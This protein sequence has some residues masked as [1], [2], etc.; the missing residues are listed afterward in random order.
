M[1][2][3]SYNVFKWAVIG[4]I[5]GLLPFV[6]PW[7][8]S[9]LVSEFFSEIALTVLWSILLLVVYISVRIRKTHPD[10]AKGLWYGWLAELS[11]GILTLII[12]F[13][14][15]FGIIYGN[16]FGD[17]FF[18][19]V[20]SNLPQ[21]A[22]QQLVLQFKGEPVLTATY[23]ARHKYT[24]EVEGKGFSRAEIQRGFAISCFDGAASTMV[25]F[26]VCDQE[27]GSQS[28][29]SCDSTAE[30]YFSK[31]SVAYGTT[32][33]NGVEFFRFDKNLS[34]PHSSVFVKEYLVA[35]RENDTRIEIEYPIKTPSSCLSE[36]EFQDI[37]SIVDSIELV[38][39]YR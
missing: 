29:G 22:P 11:A 4:F 30:S 8:L 6:A 18:Y 10:I 2:K 23:P 26:L 17:Q 14:F 12:G 13:V 20:S 25:S 39:R 32:T 31:R 5:I 36:S 21:R 28:G 34:F 1:Y 19:N 24:S 16:I 35:F 15:F 7:L 9:K 37:R 27:F 33:I 38:G 3:V